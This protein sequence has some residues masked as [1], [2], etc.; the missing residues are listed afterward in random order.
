MLIEMIEG[1][2]LE[3]EIQRQGGIFHM[4]L[5]RVLDQMAT[6]ISQISNLTFYG[7]DRLG[8]GDSTRSPCLVRFK[9]FDER[10]QN[11]L[12]AFCIGLI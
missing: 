10:L 7:I 1:E 12:I 2:T 9:R 5:Q 8:F 4:Q 11:W 3:Q 6:Y